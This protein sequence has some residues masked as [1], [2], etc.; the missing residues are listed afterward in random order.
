MNKKIVKVENIQIGKGFCVIGGPCA[1]ESKS[2]L[3]E[4]V[5]AIK[6]NI[7]IL[8]G[9]AFKPRTSP[10]SFQGLGEDGLKILK[11]VSSK[12]NIPTVTEVM[13]TRQVEL[14]ASYA[15][16]LQIGARNMQNYPLLR[17]AGKSGKPVLLKRGFGNKIKEWLLA[18]EYIKKEGNNQIILCERGIRTFEDSLRFT[19]DLA[20][21]LLAK[22]KSIYPVI[23]D[24]SHATGNPDLIAPLVKAA[25]AAGIDGVMVEVHCNPTD[26]KSD[27][28]QQLTPK[29]FN[30]IFAQF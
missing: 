17:E 29:Q 15:D 18:A 16:M 26:A 27:S 28:D 10:D 11:E 30:N 23:I 21:A 4:T 7:D 14:V 8:R 3:L 12:L 2:Q 25:K 19:L 6:E 20:G 13:D 9:G 1:V 24:P 5:E 22:K